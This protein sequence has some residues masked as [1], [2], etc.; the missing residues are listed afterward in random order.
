[1]QGWRLFFYSDEGHES[2]HVHA[3]KGEAECKF[4]IRPKL[5]EIEEEWSFNLSPRLR[6]EVRQI[7]F[8][9]LDLIADEWNRHLGGH[10]NA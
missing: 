8:A 7:I 10:R 2:M 6:R 3:R 1:M 4:W 5:Y 9:H